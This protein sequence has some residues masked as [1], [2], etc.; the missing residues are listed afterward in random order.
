MECNG[1]QRDDRNTTGIQGYNSLQIQGDTEMT[2]LVKVLME[3]D[4]MTLE[5]AMEAVANARKLVVDEYADPEEVLLE[6]FGL[7]PDYIFDLLG[8]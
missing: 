3:R 6:E 4:G 7:E 5:D 1:I 8:W 2:E